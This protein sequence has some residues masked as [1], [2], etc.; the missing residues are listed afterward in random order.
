MQVYVE[1]ALAENFCMDFVLLYSA[2]IITKNTCGIFKVAASSLFGAIFAV[3]V[4]MFSLGTAVAVILKIVCGLLLA[5]LAGRF[6][7]IK[8]YVKF[9]LIFFALTAFEGGAMLGIFMLAGVDYS[10]GEGWVLSSVPI[11]IPLFFGL[12]LLLVCKRLAV[13]I[14][15]KYSK[16]TVEITAFVGEKCAKTKAFYD[17]GNSVYYMGSPVSVVPYDFAKKLI[18]VEGI[19][20]CTTV[21]TVAGE[22][23]LPIFTADKII[24]GSDGNKKTLYKI[25]LGVSEKD[26]Q[27]AVLHPDL[28]NYE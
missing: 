17:S 19:K 8:S 26:I 16:N 24:I 23:K 7:S 13:K 6:N 9:T 28:A 5:A 25:R 3:L 12:I 27:K 14:S 1:Y 2:K 21:H 20:K 15:A 10:E 18:K 4:A 22:Q 11:G